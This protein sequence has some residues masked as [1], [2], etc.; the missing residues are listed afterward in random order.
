MLFAKKV[1]VWL[2]C[3][4]VI[5][6]VVQPGAT[7]TSKDVDVTCPLCH[8]TFKANMD[9]SSSRLGMR[10]DLKPLGPI[11]APW[12]VPKCPKCHFIVYDQELSETN[13][14]LLHKFVSSKKYQDMSVDNS[15]YFLLAKIYEVVGMDIY[16]IAHTY[17]KASWQV[18]KDQA[19]CAK[20]LEAS[21]AKFQLFL[22]LNKKISSQYIIAELVSGEIERRTGKFDQ[23]AARFNRIQ[24]LSE[25][26]GSD[27]VAAIIEYQLELIAAKDKGPHEIK[28]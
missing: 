18:E 21:L 26:S 28:M 20:Y 24:K 5:I 22:S 13:L 27:N 23:A 12:N 6:L 25:F 7:Q 15:T 14:E 8:T 2:I 4:S 10:L 1:S 9:V 11:P 16:E 19:K 3:L 17:L